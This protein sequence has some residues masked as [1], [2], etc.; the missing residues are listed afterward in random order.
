MQLEE[1]QDISDGS[2]SNSRC[3]AARKARLQ[4]PAPASG[5]APLQTAV[6]RVARARPPPAL[7]PQMNT[8]PRAL[9][10]RHTKDS[11]MQYAF[12][13]KRQRKRKYDWFVSLSK[14]RSVIV[15]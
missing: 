8:F 5:E 3:D 15:P 7:Q 6:V 13:K 2:T 14:K 9:E 11:N 12:G 1:L 10:A 4:S